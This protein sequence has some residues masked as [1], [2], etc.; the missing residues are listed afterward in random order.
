MVKSA[1]GQPWQEQELIP[2]FQ[3]APNGRFSAQRGFHKNHD[4]TGVLVELG[5]RGC[6]KQT[7]PRQAGRP[8]SKTLH[9][10]EESHSEEEDEELTQMAQT[11][12]NEG[13]QIVQS[14]PMCKRHGKIRLGLG[15]TWSKVVLGQGSIENKGFSYI[16]WR[17]GKDLSSGERDWE[18]PSR[19]S[20]LQ[21]LLES[22]VL[23]RVSRLRASK[24]GG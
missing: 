6:L 11:A 7:G 9:K 12:L 21:S 23:D 1:N 18:E 4:R 10:G 16:C 14:Q 8:Q 15:N 3:R 24:L 20:E 19:F 13:S 22:G 2:P 17:G 5:G